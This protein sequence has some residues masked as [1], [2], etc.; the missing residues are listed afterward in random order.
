MARTRRW[1][2]RLGETLLWGTALAAALGVGLGGG[3]ARG[4]LPIETIGRVET[5]P[6]PYPPHWLF[7]GDPVARRTALVDLEDGRL[8][9]ILDSGFGLPQTLHP[10]K[11]AEIYVAETHY[12]R[13]AR[14]VRS[15]VLTVYDAATLAPVDEVVLPP[16]R[17]LSATPTGH[18]ALSDDDRFAAIFNLTPATTLSIVD[19][20]ERRFVG[21]IETPGCSLVYPVGARRFVSLCM[22]GGLLLVTL[23]DAGHAAD[24]RRTAPFFDPEKDPVTEKAARLE[25]RWYFVSFEGWVHPVSF[26]AEE[27]VF[28]ERWSLVSDAERADD[29]RIGGS[30]HLAI[31]R[32]SGRAYALM[33]R[34]P[35]DSHKQAG[36]EVWVYD[37]ETRQRIQ[38]IELRN[39][40]FTY[41]GVPIE[42]P[43][44]WNRLLQWFADR[45]MLATPELGVESIAVTQ[46]DAPR[47]A[48]SGAFSGGIA[49]YDALTGEFQGRV[50]SGNMTNL[51]LET[52]W[53]PPGE[54]AP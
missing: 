44:P 7:V 20:A 51:V 41:L 27:P 6:L 40:G 23:D 16:K 36:N 13:G 4:D 25:D 31:H 49:T 30:Q 37:I 39:P 34:G 53:R 43:T 35:E 33:H 17:A 38:R 1:S 3:I 32:A 24:V 2:A 9:G 26:A 21:E 14:G 48:T 54:R 22:N 45:I 47:L 52:P 15:D 18:T 29:W 42:A 10:A 19:V 28:E 5:V 46:D 50:F 8:I 12:S 11:R